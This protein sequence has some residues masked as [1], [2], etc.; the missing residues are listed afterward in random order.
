MEENV[1][2][3]YPGWK[4]AA[5]QIVKRV[6]AEGYGVMISHENLLAM[7]DMK[8]PEAGTAEDFKKYAFELLTNTVNLTKSLLE[9]HN[10]CLHNVRGQGY[11]VL[12]PD[13]QVTIAAD[14]RIKKALHHVGQALMVLTHVDG[15]ALSYDGQ[16]E[17]VR[18]LGKVGFLFSALSKKKK[19]GNGGDEG[20]LAL[21]E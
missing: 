16:Q 5:D 1:T 3:L 15:E 4:E 8:T 11:Q 10:L 7:M 19:V 14:K 9:E 20:Q 17:Q 18:R 21:P 13:D 6:S 2:K 12:H